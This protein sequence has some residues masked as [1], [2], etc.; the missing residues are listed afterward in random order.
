[1]GQ[2]EKHQK[3]K[4]QGEGNRE[5]DRRYRNAASDH[6]ESGKV[7]EAARRAAEELEDSSQERALD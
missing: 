3:E 5:A 1:M 7:E 6:A 2:E 4:N